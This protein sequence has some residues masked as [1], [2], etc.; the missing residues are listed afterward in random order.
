M[1]AATTATATQATTA[2]HE[3]AI[4]DSSRQQGSAI[5]V[6]AV[7]AIPD[8]QE[9]EVGT[10]DQ[11][12][13]GGTEAEEDT[14]AATAEADMEAEDT[15]VVLM[16]A[17]D[18]GVVLMEAEV[19][20]AVDMAL[21]TAGAIVSGLHTRTTVA[22]TTTMATTTTGPANKGHQTRTTH[23]RATATIPS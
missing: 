20:E 14:G 15:G 13:M 4:T 1:V 19:M 12:H 10:I 17:E 3:R 9:V 7:E 2:P 5:H 11:V 8:T 22:T 23:V 18:T 16:E 21:D 6:A